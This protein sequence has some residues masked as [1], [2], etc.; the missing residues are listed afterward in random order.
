MKDFFNR[1]IKKN[2]S[3]PIFVKLNKILF[4]K[5]KKGIILTKKP[6]GRVLMSSSLLKKVSRLL[7]LDETAEN[8]SEIRELVSEIF[9][10]SCELYELT[11]S[12]ALPG[13]SKK[14]LSLCLG[15]LRALNNN[16][17]RA[18]KECDFCF[19]ELDRLLEGV[20]LCS[21]ILLSEK[22]VKLSFEPEK[23]AASC[24]PSLIIDA[25]L[26]LI[27]NA[28]KF[29]R[30][31]I[32]VALSSGARQCVISVSDSAKDCDLAFLK[33]KSGLLSV[34]NTARL[35]GGRLL[36]SAS[37]DTFSARMALSLDLPRGKRYRS[38]P[39]TSYL[40]NRFSPVHI[41]LCDCT[42]EMIFN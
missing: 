12:E 26:N 29:S 15:K 17:E 16:K 31:D 34:R 32:R 20:C 35:H 25:F 37:G 22:N 8:E 41:G 27:S 9:S 24:C 2:V 18:L 1:K 19:V 30:G 3:F 40:E 7:S 36:F 14:I 42:D 5:A 21:D 10:R 38:P 6:K 28:V 23:I 39:F 13:R 11:E 33:P 4:I